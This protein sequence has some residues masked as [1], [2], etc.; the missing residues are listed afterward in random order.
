VKDTFE[1][2]PAPQVNLRGDASGVS[3]SA[4]IGNFTM[5]SFSVGV[6]GVRFTD[7]AK[8][9]AENT[10]RDG[11]GWKNERLGVGV[12]L[13]MNEP[14]ATLGAINVEANGQEL[15]VGMVPAA[16]APMPVPLY[17]GTKRER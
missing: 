16:P 6:A 7:A 10:A 9:T 2:A 12:H 3:G 1:R 5:A 8:N 11:L 4:Q 15:V 14:G 13:T 17:F